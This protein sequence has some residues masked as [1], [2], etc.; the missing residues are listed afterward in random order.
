MYVRRI[1]MSH[2][3]GK[4]KREKR[5][6]RRRGWWVRPARSTHTRRRHARNATRCPTSPPPFTS[7][8]SSS[9]PLLLAGRPG[10]RPEPCALPLRMRAASC[11]ARHQL[12]R[13][14]NTP[15]TKR[16]AHAHSGLVAS[17]RA[18][19]QSACFSNQ[20]HD[21][22]PQ[23]GGPQAPGPDAPN[24]TSSLNTPSRPPPSRVHSA[25]TSSA[26]PATT[27][28]PPHQM[29]SRRDRLPRACAFPFAPQSAA[30]DAPG[31]A[32]CVAWRGRTA[33]VRQAEHPRDDDSPKTSGGAAPGLLAQP[34]PPRRRRPASSA[35]TAGG[36][37]AW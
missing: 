26:G 6:G 25:P 10:N 16:R 34:S 8:S 15:P 12:R 29:T 14:E 9:L 1:H 28:L 36:E 11:D 3:R 13:E 18:K 27:T 20:Q 4:A 23:L 35:V 30:D 7:T 24:I 17:P 5:G 33:L 19:P 2:A 22:A 21:P 31:S 32:V 37:G